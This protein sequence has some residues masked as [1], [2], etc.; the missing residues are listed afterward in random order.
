MIGVLAA[1]NLNS[2]K[3]LKEIREKTELEY[4]KRVKII[5]GGIE[6]RVNDGTFAWRQIN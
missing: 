6:R 3:I 4:L 5:S 2:E 1:K